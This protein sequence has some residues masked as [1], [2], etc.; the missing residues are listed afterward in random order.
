MSKEFTNT[1]APGVLDLVPY[2]AGKTI[3]QICQEKGIDAT[4]KL[5]SNENPLGTSPKA[6]ATLSAPKDYSPH[7][8]PDAGA[9]DLRGAI[10]ESL[11]IDPSMVV[12]G[13][14]SNE[15]LEMAATLALR[16]G[17]KAVY[18]QHAFI[19]YHLATYA[20]GAT[21]VVVPASNFG[22]DLGLMAEACQDEGVGAVFVANPNNPTGSWHG[23]EVIKHFVEQVPRRVLVVLDEAYHEYVDKGAGETLGLLEKHDNLVITRTF[24]KIHG[25]AGLRLGYGIAGETIMA[26][27][28]RVRQPFNANSAGQL[29]AIASLRDLEFLKLSRKTNEE[30]KKQLMEGFAALGYPTMFSQANFVPFYSGDSQKT[31]DTLLE[32]GVITR[33]ID[34]YGLE[35]W[36]RATVGTKEQNETLLKA[37][38]KRN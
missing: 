16:P 32:G 3:E 37:L 30:G 28:N 31:N 9:V 22:H 35:G 1:L 34:E 36:L 26:L 7:L 10:G 2:K 17:R 27:F 13:N 21:P 29:A 38:P 6:M 25:L 20:R 24:S 15:V 4:I 19:V 5:S 33:Q 14:G 12:C 18:S 23:F 11:G 8:Y